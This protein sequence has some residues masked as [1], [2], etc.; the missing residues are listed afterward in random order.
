MSAGKIPAIAALLL[1]FFIL[2]PI[3]PLYAVPPWLHVEGNKIKDPNGNV[4]VLRGV[5]TVDLGATQL[6]YGGAINMINR[7]TNKNDTHGNS[8]GWYPRVIRFAIYPSDEEDFSSPFTFTPGSNTFYDTLLRPVVDYCKTKNLY[9]IIDWHYVGNDTWTKVSQTSEFWEYMAPRFANDSHVLFELFNE[10]LNTSSGDETADW[11]SCRTDMQTWINIIRPYAPNNLILVAG[12]SYSQIIG[13]AATYPLT[14]DNIVIVSHI[15][16]G[17]WT[18]YWGD[19]QWYKNH[20]TTCAAVYPVFMTEWGFCQS[21]SSQGLRGTVTNY[22]QPLMDFM[23]GL[24]IS[25]SAWVASYDW[26]PPMFNSDWTLRVGEGEMGG[27]LKDTLYLRRNDDQPNRPAGVVVVKKC[28]ATA[29]SKA[30]SDKISFSGTMD[31]TADDFNEANAV[32]VTIDSND[33]VSP[34]VLTFPINGKTFK[35]KNGMYS[36]SGTENKLRKSFT[37]NVKTRKFAFSASNVDLLG[38]GCPLNVRIEIDGY[39]G[40][41]EIDEA[42]VNGP[43]VPIPI[44]L[45][46]GVKNVLRVDKCTVKQNNKKPNSDQLL[47]KGALAVEDTAVNMVNEEF[48]ATLGAQT[49]TL[50]AGS[51]KAGKGKFT[52]SKAPVTE[53]NIPAGTAAATFNFNL[54]SFILTI[55]DAN[56]PAISGDVDFGVAFADYNEVDQVTFP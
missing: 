2:R 45:M 51:F 50:P 25:S 4:V 7:L 28:A 55:K 38:L 13:P 33:I 26:Q 54:C 47:V 41:A 12:P 52:C 35:V 16:P 30:G 8:P 36:Y 21:S 34:C 15:Y 40:T 31:A 10:P 27:F 11:L 56:I 48:V 6:W 1:S 43:R 53:S 22:G 39:V 32:K 17:H 24:K 29:G 5:D 18:G 19:P 14:G 9:A 37:Y 46:M 49:F 20:I 23:E 3:T 44:L 42:I